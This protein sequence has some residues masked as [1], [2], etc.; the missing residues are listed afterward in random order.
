MK[1]I[2]IVVFLVRALGYRVLTI[3]KFQ[4]NNNF[5]TNEFNNNYYGYRWILLIKN[6][7]LF[8]LCQLIANK[9]IMDGMRTWMETHW[10][11]DDHLNC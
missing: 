4:R 7:F 1:I 3:N 11:V 9:R 10:S 2:I 8:S 6:G 5:E